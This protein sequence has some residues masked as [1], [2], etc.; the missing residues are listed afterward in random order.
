[1][2]TVATPP[3]LIG[4]TVSPVPDLSPT[5]AAQQVHTS[6]DV[7]NESIVGRTLSATLSLYAVFIGG[8]FFAPVVPNILYLLFYVA[9]VE[10]FVYVTYKAAGWTWSFVSRASVAAASV[11]GYLVGLGTYRTVKWYIQGAESEK[12]IKQTLAGMQV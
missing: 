12:I 6:S 8:M 3:F 4:P 11:L 2:T 7:Q 5:P 9:I 10:I 1:M